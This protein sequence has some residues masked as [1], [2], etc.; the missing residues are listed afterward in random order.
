MIDEQAQK[1]YKQLELKYQKLFD[2]LFDERREVL[3]GKMKDS[4]DHLNTYIIR[5]HELEDKK[6]KDIQVEGLRVEDIVLQT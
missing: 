1:L 5:T 3:D 4:S 2:G 6:F